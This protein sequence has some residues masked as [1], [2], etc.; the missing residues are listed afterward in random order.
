MNRDPIVDE[1]RRAADELRQVAEVTR[2]TQ[3][4]LE[5]ALRA[6]EEAT[7]EGADVRPTVAVLGPQAARVQVVDALAG[8]AVLASAARSARAGSRVTFVKH[9]A[10]IECVAHSRN[11][12]RVVRFSQRVPDRS[13][14][15]EKRL[16]QA[17]GDRAKAAG[18]IVERERR[19]AEARSREGAAREAAE[20]STGAEE[21][22]DTT[23][24]HA[25]SVRPA[26]PP[27]WWAFWLWIARLFAMLFGRAAAPGQDERE[28]ARDARKEERRRLGEALRG[29]A[30][31]AQDR[32]AALEREGSEDEA[33]P[34]AERA[35]E[36]L[37]GERARYA[38]E[39][40]DE[41]LAHLAHAGD[42]VAELRIEYPAV[43]L[44]EGVTLLDI[45]TPDGEEARRV[46]S[47][48]VM[49][50]AHGFVVVQDPTRPMPP[51]L[52][53][54]IEEVTSVVPRLFTVPATEDGPAMSDR[55][56][57][58]R[59]EGTRIA[60]R[61]AAMR[62]RSCLPAL[63]T[64]RDDAE[65]THR[66]RLVTLEGQ[67]LP[68][69]AEFRARQLERV[70]T[71]IEQGVDDALKSADAHLRRDLDALRARWI[72]A[73]ASCS[74][75]SELVSLAAEID[76]SVASGVAQTLDGTTKRVDE[77]LRKV[78]QSI[79]MLTLDELRAHYPL[80][81]RLGTEL[82]P[83]LAVDWSQAQ[84]TVAPVLAPVGLATAA[85]EKKR[86][87]VGLGG[88]AL[89]AA[90]GTAILPGI[91]SAIGAVV[92]V[93]AGFLP[94]SD[95]LRKDCLA[96]VESC[97]GDAQKRALELLAARRADLARVL[98]E[99]LNAGLAGA[100]ERH[101]EAIARL[102]EVER[103]AIAA[104]RETLAALEEARTTLTRNEVRLERLAAAPQREAR[105]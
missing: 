64:A 9:A 26:A 30:R 72:E 60:A 16:E 42:D 63:K 34:R 32:V 98:H 15:F 89:G 52:V 70:R 7:R 80:A 36:R 14:L 100:F 73:V 96:R 57:S 103:R 2:A 91:G 44:P 6:A 101:E 71:A 85:F 65:A 56:R 68:D 47:A 53:S 25:Q 46:A 39:R 54:L 90:I 5:L 51:P 49:R 50:E 45:A 23:L 3:P 12:R 29:E 35:I 66:K 87:T 84:Q 21:P 38:Q 27:P 61:S 18:V 11:G 19:L 78:T 58:V 48:A 105:D 41:F 55:L 31:A 95:G 37:T 43:H 13:G 93:F 28:A 102:Q 10:A 4:E 8:A 22:E 20:R 99:T 67:R 97:I 40:R 62:L 104:E 1:L 86:V 74:G 69:P 33:V 83:P 17:R 82:L 24:V 92:G 79:E 77:E 88:A 94:G 76:R 75:R 59:A 81:R